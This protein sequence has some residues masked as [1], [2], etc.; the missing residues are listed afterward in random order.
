MEIE[1]DKYQKEVVNYSGNKFLCV[2]AGPGAGKTRVIV[3]RVKKLLE[4]SEPESLLVITFTIKAAEELKERLINSG[5]SKNDVYKMQISTIHSF[6]LKILKNSDVLD[7]DVMDDGMGEKKNMFI[8][9][10]IRELGFYDEYYLPYSEIKDVMRKYDEYCTFKVDTQQLVNY[11]SQ[12]RPVSLDYID[13]VHEHMVQN[14]GAFPRNEVLENDD[15]AESWYN[16]KYYKIAK[17]YP[18]Y[19]NLL[20]ANHAIDYG[21][22]QIQTLEFLQENPETIYKNI[23]VDE[24][25]DTDPVQMSI[26]E[27]LMENADTFLV[28]G[29]INQSIYSFRGC[30]D[31]FFEYIYENHSDRFLRKVLPTNYR[32]TNEII[33]L[34]DDFISHQN[35]GEKLH[36][37]GDRNVSRNIY[38]LGNEK[39]QHEAE[40]ISKIVKYLHDEGKIKNYR[41]VAILTRSIKKATVRNLVKEF[42]KLDI[43]YQIKGLDDLVEKPEV[44]SILTLIFHLIRS[45]DPHYPITI[46]WESWLNL[47]AYAGV[48]FE[49]KLFDL[50]P[51]T[52]EILIRLQDN[53]EKSVIDVRNRIDPRD[54]PFKEY[55]EAC[56]GSDEVLEKLFSLVERPILTNEN[57][58]EFGITD[59]DDIEFFKRL[60]GLRDEIN[61]DD[62]ASRP[63]ILEVYMKLLTEFTGYLNVDFIRDAKN[64]EELKNISVF[65]NT[66]YNF[67]QLRDS[68]DLEGVFWF[69]YSNIRKFESYNDNSKDS[70]QI[71]TVH[72]AK[73]LEFPFVF[74]AALDRRYF[75]VH[76]ENPMV[77][78]YVKGSPSYFTPFEFLE[79]KGPYF[80]SEIEEYNHDLEEE[81]IIYVAMTRAQDTMIISSLLNKRILKR[82]KANIRRDNMQGIASTF[83]GP[84]C[85]QKLINNNL[86]MIRFIDMDNLEFEDRICEVKQPSKEKVNLSFS[87]I[88]TYLECPLK[89]DLA[90]DIIFK[91]SQEKPQSDGIFVHNVFE[92]VNNLKRQGSYVGE[93]TVRDIVYN[94]YMNY[95]FNKNDF[96]K[97][98]AFSDDIVEYYRNCDFKVLDVE[99][100]FDI[101]GEKYNLN[102]F[103]DLIYERDGKIGILDY[104]N[105]FYNEKNYGKYKR[106][107]Y[108][109]MLALGEKNQKY[110]NAN[111]EELLIYAV[112][113]REFIPVPVDLK[114]LDE[115]KQE[116][117]FVSM[118]VEDKNYDKSV[119]KHCEYCNYSKICGE[120]K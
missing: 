87:S 2:E 112:R 40:N 60:N 18:T 15:F 54:K 116:L 5:I 88:E 37:I 22:L 104:K 8:G 115:V 62:Y 33:Q 53:F 83:K 46:R 108:V 10:H 29:D 73:G 6:C 64:Y 71:M 72:G 49:Q 119:G 36:P 55:M 118:N 68:K 16:A 52:K 39:S 50:S 19:L 48:D 20:K 75:P 99:Y 66:F 17:S 78:D 41:E 84:N 4:N 102:G 24:F 100:R 89:Y 14:N 28:V 77:N 57:I 111:I 70:V 58:V 101:K 32:S 51:E 30:G 92:V 9:K 47:K 56:R 90:Y 43:P 69:I 105:T 120:N 45:N 67:E 91:T 81:R 117:E 34:A 94:L 74:L 96:K 61:C 82:L 65:T 31:N 23:L 114:E 44:K 1:L 109:Y 3:E 110:E 7:L 76:Y 80:E 103:I 85:I 113:S 12:N 13:F 86:G 26:F 25:Q 97:L 95:N 27:I 11:I 106:Q 107:L 38:F 93:E 59:E 98:T 35:E 42:D 79:Y 21:Q 63:T